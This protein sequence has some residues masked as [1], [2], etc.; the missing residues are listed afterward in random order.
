MSQKIG[1]NDLKAYGASN[2][3][4]YY[5]N[6]SRPD[7]SREEDG[8]FNI[9]GVPELKGLSRAEMIAALNTMAWDSKC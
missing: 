8:S 9:H 3:I 2:E 5:F 7:I 6:T 4:L 1:Y